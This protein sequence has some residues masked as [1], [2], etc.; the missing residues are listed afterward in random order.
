VFNKYY[1][2]ELLNLRERA[3]EFSKVH[4]A[5]APLLSGPSS[6]PDVER[7][8]EGVSFLTGLLQKK[9]DDEFPELIHGLIDLIFPYYLKPIPSTSIVT[10]SPKP[11]LMET[12]FVPAGTSL[13]SVSIEDTECLFRTCFDLDVHPLELVSAELIQE[14]GQRDR[15]R[16]HF[17][18]IGIHLSQ[19]EPKN[20]G[21]FLGG[22]FTQATDLF[23]LLTR[24]VETISIA[25]EGGGG[26]GVLSPKDLKPIGFDMKNTLIPFPTQIFQGYRILQEYFILPEKFLFL[27]LQG[28]EKWQNKGDGTAFDI[29]FELASA[30]MPCAG[31]QPVHPRGGPHFVGSPTGKNTSEALDGTDAKSADLQCG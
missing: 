24:Y 9:L 23:A 2:Q 27:E 3:K 19:W 30:P 31:D 20:L 4:P 10:F 13:A 16:L 25:P 8:L 11:G 21:F 18:L 1:Q 5:L 17:E 15:I 7:L 22:N 29:I 26:K 14:P 12:I 28:W 6:D